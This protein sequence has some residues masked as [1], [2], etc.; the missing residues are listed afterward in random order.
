[1][2]VGVRIDN[3]EAFTW[4][5][6]E[7]SLLQILV[8]VAIIQIKPLKAEVGKGFVWTVFEHELVDPKSHINVVN[9][10]Q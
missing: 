9:R 1:M 8:V 7:L 10:L 2:R 6:V 5:N 3:V 4:V